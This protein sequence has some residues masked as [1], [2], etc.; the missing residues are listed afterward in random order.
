MLDI[1]DIFVTIISRNLHTQIFNLID[2]CSDHSPVML[3]LDCLPQTK[4]NA[5]ALFQIPTDWEKFSTTLSEKTCLKLC[6][7]TPSDIDDAAN[8][9]TTNIHNS[10]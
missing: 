5:T 10:V 1:L 7:K 6:L 3:S 9:L 8:L 2:P 4:I